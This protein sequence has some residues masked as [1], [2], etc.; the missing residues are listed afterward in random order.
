MSNAQID[1]E[2]LPEAPK[3][4]EQSFFPCA[5]H[6]TGARLGRRRIVVRAGKVDQ[7]LGA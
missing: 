7:G 6:L 1:V 4:I 5:S 3:D 2:H